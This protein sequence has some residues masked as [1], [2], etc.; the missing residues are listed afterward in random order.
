MPRPVGLDGPGGELLELDFGGGDQLTGEGA[1]L[2][3][4]DPGVGVAAGCAPP[5]GLVVVRPAVGV[6]VLVGVGVPRGQD[7]FAGVEER[8]ELVEALL[9][10]DAWRGGW[11]GHRGSF[12]SHRVRAAEELEAPT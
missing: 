1:D 8:G 3:G 11:G 10:D 9:M 2:C 7:L 4:G 6:G 5:V 12:I